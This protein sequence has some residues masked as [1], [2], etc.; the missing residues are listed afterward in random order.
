M[1]HQMSYSHRL[2]AMKILE[3]PC[4]VC[5]WPILWETKIQ[6]QPP[7]SKLI[8]DIVILYCFIGYQVEIPP[9][10][11]LGGYKTMLC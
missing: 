8:R 5:G 6:L 7:L 4:R 9:T 1:D 2:T 11:I 10:S 3:E